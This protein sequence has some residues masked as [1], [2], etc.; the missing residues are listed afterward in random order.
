MPTTHYD[1]LG[2]TSDAPEDLIRRALAKQ[3]RTWVPRQ[4]S[5]DAGKRQI[6]ETQIGRLDR[7]ETTLLNPTRRREY[8][9]SL[10]IARGER[11]A[12]TP[13]NRPFATVETLWTG[14]DGHVAGVRADLGVTQGSAVKLSVLTRLLRDRPDLR[15]AF[16]CARDGSDI[17]ATLELSLIHI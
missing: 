13:A 3:R 2:V 5:S 16:G 4:N 1:E 8:D 11:P 7:I 14:T 9:R 10:A 15:A 6:A 17:A 12:P